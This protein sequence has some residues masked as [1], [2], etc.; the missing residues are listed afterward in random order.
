MLPKDSKKRP[1]IILTDNR[2][3]C[4]KSLRFLAKRAANWYKIGTGTIGFTFYEILSNADTFDFR[5]LL[6]NRLHR[7]ELD[8]W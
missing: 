8:W 6:L 7:G 3:S 2:W 4:T 1:P 5:L